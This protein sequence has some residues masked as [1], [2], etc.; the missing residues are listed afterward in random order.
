MLKK[1]LTIL[2]TALCCV[3]C[4]ENTF[5]EKDVFVVKS[6]EISEQIKKEHNYKY[7]YYLH[8]LQKYHGYDKAIIEEVYYYS[9]EKYELGDTLRLFNTNEIKFEKK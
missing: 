2:T 3:S 5:R 4:V 8:W 6:V 7:K 9:N 1:I